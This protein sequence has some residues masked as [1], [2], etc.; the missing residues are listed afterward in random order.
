MKT[1]FNVAHSQPNSGNYN[2]NY[3]LS[4]DLE[5]AKLRKAVPLYDNLCLQHI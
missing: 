4:V 2:L 3:M 5:D 1:R